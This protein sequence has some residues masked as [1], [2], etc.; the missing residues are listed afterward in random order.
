MRED[1]RSKIVE[2]VQGEVDCFKRNCGKLGKNQQEF[3]NRVWHILGESDRGEPGRSATKGVA[4]ESDGEQPEISQGTQP[5]VSQR[6]APAPNPD[7]SEKPWKD[8]E[9]KAR[10]DYL[11]TRAGEYPEARDVDWLRGRF[12]L[13]NVAGKELLQRIKAYA[14]RKVAEIDDAKAK[15]VPDI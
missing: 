3:V 15:E 1:Y 7:D 12:K 11:H 4:S 10:E 9:V 13:S 2:K 6:I 5:K 8:W 14:N